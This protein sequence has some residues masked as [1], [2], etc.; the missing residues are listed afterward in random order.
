M[1]L[2]SSLQEDVYENDVGP[3]CR[4]RKISYRQLESGE[5]TRIYHLTKKKG[6]IKETPS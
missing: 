4:A 3:M 5:A 1:D 6:E 2:V